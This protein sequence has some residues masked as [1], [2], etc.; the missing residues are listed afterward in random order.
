M[1][2]TEQGMPMGRVASAAVTDEGHVFCFCRG[3]TL[4]LAEKFA[5]V[6]KYRNKPRKPLRAR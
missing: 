2:V 3:L 6:S 5:I 1:V 4:T